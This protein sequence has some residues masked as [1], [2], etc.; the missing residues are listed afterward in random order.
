LGFERNVTHLDGRTITIGR[1]GTTQPGEV[2][3]IEGEG[4]PAYTDVPQGDMYIEYTVVLP[5]KI[6]DASRSSECT[7]LPSRRVER[8]GLADTSQSWRRSSGRVPAGHSA[9]ETSFEQ[10]STVHIPV[11][12]IP[13]MHLPIVAAIKGTSS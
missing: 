7:L 2:E 12:G 1:S 5:A 4:M 6:S 9:L 10:S 8:H 11:D 3:V 13:R